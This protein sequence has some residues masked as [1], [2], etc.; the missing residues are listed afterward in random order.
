[1]TTYNAI[2]ASKTLFT[3]E[4]MCDVSCLI[5]RFEDGSCKNN[6]TNTNLFLKIKRG[7]ANLV[8]SPDNVYANPVVCC[9]V[10]NL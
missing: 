8:N 10:S 6:N 7:V 4:D 3:S 2:Q 1:M 9:Y 5:A